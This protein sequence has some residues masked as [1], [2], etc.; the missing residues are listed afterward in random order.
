VD[1]GS[2][3]DWG[4]HSGTGTGLWWIVVVRDV[5]VGTVALGQICGL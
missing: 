2:E 4:G 3:R 5:G 1:S